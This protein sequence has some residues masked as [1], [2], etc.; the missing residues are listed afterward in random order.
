MRAAQ[1]GKEKSIEEIEFFFYAP[2]GNRNER[3]A[4]AVVAVAKWNLTYCIRAI[5]LSAVLQKGTA[6]PPDVS[7]N[8]ER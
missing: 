5:L 6:R 1:R 8:N 7:R 3:A 2:I 4:V